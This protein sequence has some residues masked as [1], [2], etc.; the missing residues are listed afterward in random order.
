MRTKFIL[1]G[2]KT[3]KR[4][5]LD[6]D[7][8]KFDGF[9]YYQMRVDI[10]GFRGLVC[11]I[12]LTSGKYRYWGTRKTGKTA[13]C[14]KGMTWLQL[15][16]DESCHVVTAKYL[17][18][19]NF[20]Q[21]FIQGIRYSDTVSIW[22]VDIIENIEYDEDGVAAFIDKFLDVVFVPHGN[23]KIADRDELDTALQSGVI[24]K[25]QYTS[26]LQECDLVVEKYCT[27][28][29]KTE[30]LCSQILSHVNDRINK[31]EK[32]FKEARTE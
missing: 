27:D 7:S 18:K 17:P 9:P 25:E 29:A 1:S 21:R 5:R 3:L 19:R 14:G 26:A 10:E 16:P 22:Y 28:I 6:R 23:V 4:K 11:L 20:I 31:G 24:S 13:V 8:W 32:P 15:V 30:I 2:V 12:K